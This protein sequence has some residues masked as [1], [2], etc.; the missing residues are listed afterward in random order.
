MA[1]SNRWAAATFAYTTRAGKETHRLALSVE[2][3]RDPVYI[4]PFTAEAIIA[5]YDEIRAFAEKYPTAK[6]NEMAR[7]N[8][9]ELTLLAVEQARKLEEMSRAMANLQETMNAR[10]GSNTVPHVLSVP[11]K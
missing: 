1:T 10:N 6:G 8:K 2:G 11:V 5:C 9:S 4:Y 7:L 3:G